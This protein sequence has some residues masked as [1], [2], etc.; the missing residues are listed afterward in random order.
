MIEGYT[1]NGLK[2]MDGF[3]QLFARFFLSFFF[4]SPKVKS[5]RCHTHTHTH[6]HTLSLSLSLSLFHTLTRILTPLLISTKIDNLYSS[7]SVFFII[8]I[9]GLF[10]FSTFA[11]LKLYATMGND[12]NFLNFYRTIVEVL[13]LKKEDCSAT[14]GLYNKLV[15]HVRDLIIFFLH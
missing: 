10:C 14:T 2:G 15:A 13:F 5:D 4:F 9:I 6:T 11:E 7:F 8:I 12:I 1:E 3:E